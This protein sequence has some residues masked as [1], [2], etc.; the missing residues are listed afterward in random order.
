MSEYLKPWSR[1]FKSLQ[2]SLL[3]I[4]SISIGS[5]SIVCCTR[6]QICPKG[7]FAPSGIEFALLLVGLLG[8]LETLDLD[9]N[10]L[11]GTLPGPGRRQCAADAGGACGWAACIEAAGLWRRCEL[12]WVQRHDRTCGAAAWRC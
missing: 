10:L 3:L 4:H 12:V 9:D 5:G 7:A 1:N 8:A 11:S 2:V 6:P